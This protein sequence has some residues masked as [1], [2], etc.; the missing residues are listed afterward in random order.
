MRV[1]VAWQGRLGWK[2]TVQKLSGPI[3][4]FIINYYLL[5]STD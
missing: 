2:L 5:N 4:P 3:D 1:K